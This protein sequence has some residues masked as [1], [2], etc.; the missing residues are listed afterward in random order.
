MQQRSIKGEQVNLV[1]AF[2]SFLQLK[3]FVHSFFWVFLNRHHVW[4]SEGAATA[5]RGFHGGCL[6]TGKEVT[7]VAWPRGSLSCGA[8]GHFVLTCCTVGLGISRHFCFLDLEFCCLKSLAFGQF[9]VVCPSCGGAGRTLMSLVELFGCSC[10]SRA[11]GSGEPSQGVPWAGQGT[12]CP[13]LGSRL[14]SL[15]HIVPSCDPQGAGAAEIRLPKELE[16]QWGQQP[17]LPVPLCA[18]RPCWVLGAVPG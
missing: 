9:W 18:P 11:Q 1:I 3:H 4:F 14:S 17:T 6:D 10:L 8:G 13:S 2:S 7:Q 5:G 16:S 15:C 12:A